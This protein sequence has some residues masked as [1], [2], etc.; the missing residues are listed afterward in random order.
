MSKYK[1]WVVLFEGLR[2]QRM[3]APIFEPIAEVKTWV[4]PT[5]EYILANWYAKRGWTPLDIAYVGE[6]EKARDAIPKIKEVIRS[7]GWKKI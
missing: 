6:F 5:F 3:I 2:G 7:K 4:R 1:V